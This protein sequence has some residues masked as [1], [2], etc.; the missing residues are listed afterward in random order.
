MLSCSCLNVLACL[1]HT[2]T[3][4]QLAAVKTVRSLLVPYACYTSAQSAAPADQN[5]LHNVLKNTII[6][7]T[8]CPW[9]LQRITM[10]CIMCCS[11]AGS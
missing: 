4:P 2:Q 3:A 10:G 11:H 1:A 8:E 6:G 5:I 7:M 9:R